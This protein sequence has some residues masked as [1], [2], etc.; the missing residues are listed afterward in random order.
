MSKLFIYSRPDFKMLFG[1]VRSVGKQAL[2]ISGDVYNQNEEKGIALCRVKYPAEKLA[3]LQLME[4]E[5][6][7]AKVKNIQVTDTDPPIMTAEAV[8]IRFTGSFEF[9][10]NGR[11]RAASVI[12]G[13]CTDMLYGDG[14]ATYAIKCGSDDSRLY[15]YDYNNPAA[16]KGKE[17]IITAIKVKGRLKAQ[18]VMALG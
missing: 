1:T 13:R 9:P 7:G 6:I 11:D 15:I 4:G 10:E 3:R 14:C 17:V 16:I 5:R 2:V 12:I 18:E 8:L